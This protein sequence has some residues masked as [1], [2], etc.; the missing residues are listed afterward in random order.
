[1]MTNYDV[2]VGM[3]LIY[4]AFS[5]AAS[6]IV[7]WW[8]AYT[9]RRARYLREALSGL[10]GPALGQAVWE[11][12]L[13]NGKAEARSPN[14]PSYIADE[15]FAVVLMYLGLMVQPTEGYGQRIE[16]RTEVASFKDHTAASPSCD[17]CQPRTAIDARGREVLASLSANAKTQAEVQDRIH[18]WYKAAMARVS[19]IYKRRTQVALAIVSLVLVIACNVD[20][21]RAWRVLATTPAAREAAANA[22]KTTSPVGVVAALGEIKLVIPFGWSENPQ[23][24]LPSRVAGLLLTWLAIVAGGPLWFDLIAMFINPRQSGAPNSAPARIVAQ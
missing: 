7:E 17:Q 21:I 23:S 9:G 3:V 4:A 24:T 19:G 15:T 14:N 1:M 11:H 20:T 13:I 16:A 12:P 18:V 10:L 22:A 2:L 5:S 6:S 8:T